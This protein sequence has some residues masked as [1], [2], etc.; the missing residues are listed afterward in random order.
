MIWDGR[1]SVRVLLIH[2]AF[3]ALDEPGGTRHHE[4]ARVLQGLGN[5]V[6]IVT[7][8]GSYLTGE[9][10]V[11]GHGIIRQVDDAGV[12]IWR[13]PGFYAWHRSFLH[14]MLS[15]LSFMIRSFLA[16]LRVRDLDLVWG[17][18]P[19]IFQAVSAAVLAR[20]HGVPFLLEIRDLWPYFAVASGVLRSG[21]I[22]AMSR[23]LE[24]Q[25]YRSADIVV[26][27]SPGFID[28][29]KAGGAHRVEMVPNGVD[30][31]AFDAAVSSVDL[32]ASLGVADG[33]LVL[34]AGAHGLS[35]DLFTVLDA[36]ELLKM[37]PEIHFALVG[38]GKEKDNLV[39]AADQRGL[40]RV[41]FLE[42]VPKRD[43]PGLLKGADAGLAI[44]MPI[45]AYKTTY[46][47]KVFDYMAA[48]LPV[49]CAID[50]VI[51]EVVEQGG[52][53][54]FVQ[55]G[56]PRAL[57][58]A[59]LKLAGDRKHAKQLGEAGRRWVSRYDR[60]L[61]ASDLDRIMKRMVRERGRQDG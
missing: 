1:L 53:G 55:P 60:A 9:R 61:L 21:P 17:T 39:A 35:N 20:W 57:A 41:H 2:Q 54:V 44:L 19:P 46:P 56:E 25:L 47:N 30:C 59:I 50:G 15:F 31:E 8:Q 51:R 29:V 7:G 6:T 49:L 14:R 32:R 36:A 10:T 26:V 37:H 48:G 24:Q 22:I 27:N 11:E 42:P 13:V 23:W 38:A 43:V 16:G 45:E 52:A 18:S 34:Y 58:D 3:A 4:M 33:F 5:S 12:A 28:H 40:T